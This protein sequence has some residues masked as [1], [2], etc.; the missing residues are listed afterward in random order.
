MELNDLVIYDLK[1]KL[2]S[3][4]AEINLPPSVAA[5]ILKDLLVELD[6]L[7]QQNIYNLMKQK[8]SEK[9]EKSDLKENQKGE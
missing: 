3:T 1:T 8:E 5:L 6:K 2:M 7:T 9:L 4:I